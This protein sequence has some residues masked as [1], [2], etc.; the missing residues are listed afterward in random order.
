M[1]D[2]QQ[3]PILCAVE[4]CSNPPAKSG[5]KTMTKCLSHLLGGKT[6]ALKPK[7]RR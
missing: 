7:V 6:K 5:A 3:L 4:G 1:N 2:Q